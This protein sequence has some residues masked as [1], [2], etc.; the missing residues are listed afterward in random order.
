[1]NGILNLLLIM[2]DI[3]PEILNHPNPP[4]KHGKEAP[5]PSSSTHISSVELSQSTSTTTSPI[6]TPKHPSRLLE[7]K[8]Y[9]STDD[10]IPSFTASPRTISSPKSIT[11]A[12]VADASESKTSIQPLI[13]KPQSVDESRS[14]AA[15]PAKTRGQTLLDGIIVPSNF[16]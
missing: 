6:S 1:M 12:V 5:T 14:P 4:A 13:E 9:S 15:S 10:T 16:L 3:T 7:S 8:K 11:A 2:L